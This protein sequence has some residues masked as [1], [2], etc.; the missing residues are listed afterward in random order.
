M[1]ITAGTWVSWTDGDG[2]ERR[3]YVEA[4]GKHMLKVNLEGGGSSLV[5]RDRVTVVPLPE[6]CGPDPLDGPFMT[7]GQL[8]DYCDEPG[9][10]VL[11]GP[12]AK[13]RGDQG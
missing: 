11:P 4:P 3:G 6:P 5:E 9:Y 2:S 13:R 7:S 1:D 10:A 8:T 12:A